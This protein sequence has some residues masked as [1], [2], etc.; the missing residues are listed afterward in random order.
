MIE[1]ALKLMGLKRQAEEIYNE[2]DN[3]VAELIEKNGFGR[4]DFDL[5]KFLDGQINNE[6]DETLMENGRYLKLELTDN[7]AAL[8]E[9]LTVWKS[10]PFKP[11]SFEL[12]PLKRCPA[13][14]K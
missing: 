9:G 13:S 2:I 8:S 1:K 12:R 14:L 5:E 10:T 6:Y 4:M 11:V 7:I 3:I